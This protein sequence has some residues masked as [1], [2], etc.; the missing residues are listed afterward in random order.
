MDSEACPW[1]NAAIP[2][3]VTGVYYFAS[4]LNNLTRDMY[5]HG[6]KEASPSRLQT[7]LCIIEICSEPLHFAVQFYFVIYI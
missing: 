2:P 3:L 1:C 7:K 6:Y 5:V 4:Q